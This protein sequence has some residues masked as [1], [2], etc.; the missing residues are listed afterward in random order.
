MCS[1]PLLFLCPAARDRVRKCDFRCLK[2][3]ARSS[4][5]RRIQNLAGQMGARQN[6]GL[7]ATG[8]QQWSRRRHRS[9]ARFGYIGRGRQ[10]VRPVATFRWTRWAWTSARA[11]IRL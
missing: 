7:E 3:G 10:N 5:P 4:L 11:F 2:R 6:P 8:T 9:L 1:G